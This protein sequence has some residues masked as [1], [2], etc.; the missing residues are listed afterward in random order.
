MFRGSIVALITPMDASGEVDWAALD[1][2]LAWHLDQGTHGIVPMG[3]TG[4]SATLDTDEHLKVIQRTIS[5]VAG[6][7]PVIAG[8]GSNATSEAIHQ[9]REAAA[10]GADACLLVSPYYNRPSQEGLFRHYEAIA[11]A[12]DVPLFLYNV[13]ARTGRDMEAETVARASELPGVVGIKE[14]CGDAERIAEI[15][16]LVRDD[17]I[18]LSG[19]DAQTMRMLELGAVGTITVTANV[20][21]KMM[22]DFCQ[23]WLDGDEAKARALDAQLQP[24]HEVLFAEPSPAPSKAALELLGLIGPGIRLPLVAATEELRAELAQR[25]KTAGVLE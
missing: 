11:Q 17:F 20:V 2:L 8:T 7:V 15:R 10:F 21:P 25:L 14:A 5:L 16:R 19:E 9:T 22:S 6:Q 3:T 4:E 1:R 23:A 24:L 12:T 13:P 18:L